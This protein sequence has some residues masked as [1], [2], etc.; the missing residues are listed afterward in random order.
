VAELRVQQLVS[1]TSRL[2]IFSSFCR[3][4]S[5][6]LPFVEAGHFYEGNIIHEPTIP[7]SMARPRQGPSSMHS[8]K[9]VGKKKQVVEN[10][11]NLI[12]FI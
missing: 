11:F 2:V 4:W 8:P 7:E 6:F 5:F 3:G 12:P 9:R 1:V 10:M